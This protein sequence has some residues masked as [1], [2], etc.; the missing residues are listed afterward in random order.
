VNI[1]KL[2]LIF[3]TSL[4]LL[5][6]ELKAEISI[7]GN[8][9][10]VETRLPDKQKIAKYKDLK[11]FDYAQKTGRPNALLLIPEWLRDT[12]YRLIKS[13]YDAGSAEL[14]LVIM[15]AVAII[16]I[17]LKVNDINPVAL[18]RRKKHNLHP[19]FEIGK[20]NITGMDFPKLI[21]QAVKQENY[22]LAIRYHYLETLAVLAG[23]GEIELREGKTNREYLHELKSNESRNVFSRLVYGFEFVWYGEFLPDEKQYQVLNTAFVVFQ[24]SLQG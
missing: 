15:L 5:P 17:I 23:K 20:E 22:R 19:L 16:A 14:F 1:R 12:L 4:F 21:D 10:S 3:L 2:F 8:S 6:S 9:S 7:P 13:I 11:S 18:F 24:K